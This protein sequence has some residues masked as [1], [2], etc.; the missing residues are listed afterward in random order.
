MRKVLI[1][2]GLGAV[3]GAILLSGRARAGAP[4]KSG[5][6]SGRVSWYGPGLEGNQTANQE[7]FN[8][9]GMTA[10]HKTLK[11]NTMVEV[12]DRLTGRSVVVRINDRGPYVGNRVLDLAQGAAEALDIIDRGVIDADMRIVG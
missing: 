8:K 6:F 10:A 2:I 11:F 7:R 5:R 1:A 12:T 4:D 9:M 3:A